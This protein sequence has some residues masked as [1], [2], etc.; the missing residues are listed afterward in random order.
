MIPVMI[1]GLFFK[2]KVEQLFGSGLTLVGSMLLLTALLLTFS[3]IAKPRPKE[4]I[5][6]WSSFVIGLSQALAVLPGLSRSG[7]TIATGLMLG[8]KK[9]EVARFSF[10]MVIV[11]V[12]GEAFFDLVGGNLSSS[13]SIPPSSLVIGFLTAFVAGAVAC[14]WMLSLVK[15]GKLIWFAFYCAVVG[16]V[17]LYLSL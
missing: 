3:Y 1:V 14:R 8:Y 4:T 15:Q 11:P 12:L 7:T 5:S 13:P 2:D 10:L 16:S 6:W 9:E 17:T